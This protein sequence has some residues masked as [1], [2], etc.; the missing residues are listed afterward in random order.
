VVEDGGSS[1]ISRGRW[2]E[3]IA[4]QYLSRLGYQILRRNYRFQRCEI[5]II[6]RNGDTLVFVEVKTRQSLRFGHPILAV[7]AVKKRHIMKAARAFIERE[8]THTTDVRFDVLT[9]LSRGQSVTIEHTRDAF[10]YS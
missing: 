7:T 3:E 10:R 6:A 2:G 5:D 4:V 9:I 8:N 1:R